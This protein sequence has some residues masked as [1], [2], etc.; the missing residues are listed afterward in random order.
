MLRDS[1]TAANAAAQL[2]KMM[3]GWQSYRVQSFLR[4]V[5][6]F[7]ICI[8]IFLLWT[9]CGLYAPY[10][11][12][13]TSSDVLLAQSPFCGE[14]QVSGGVAA[15][16]LNTFEVFTTDTINGMTLADTYVQQCY[17]N[18]TEDAG[19]RCIS[20]PSQSLPFSTSNGEFPFDDKEVCILV[21]SAVMTLDTGLLD[22]SRDFGINARHEDTVQYR[23]VSTCSPL[24]T[25]GYANIIN[26]TGTP[27]AADY[28]P[29]SLL[30]H[31]DEVDDLASLI[32]HDRER[33][34]S[35]ICTDRKTTTTSHI[36]TNTTRCSIQSVTP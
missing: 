30:G 36:N 33:Y 1:N 21:N 26:T 14:P 8:A 2:L 27:L 7:I 35:N 31:D 34:S 5:V 19:A 17:G 9:V 23:R 15:E 10:I 28:L 29:V 4:T 16:D 6:Y 24:H 11:Y 13:R 32:L 12:T 22:S 18:G 20:Y 3:F 25:T